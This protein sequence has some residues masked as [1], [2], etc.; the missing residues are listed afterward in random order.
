[1]G[2]SGECV[3]AAQGG[4]L[5]YMYMYVY[6]YV[7]MYVYMYMYMYMYVYVYVYMYVYMHMYMYVY[8]YAY[9]Y[10]YM[11]VCVYVRVYVYVYMYVHVC[12]YVYVSRNGPR[13]HARSSRGH[14][15]ERN[16]LEKPGMAT[17][18]PRNPKNQPKSR[19]F[20][21]RPS[22]NILQFSIDFG[23]SH[24]KMKKTFVGYFFGFLGVLV[25]IPGIS[26]RLR[27]GSQRRESGVPFRPVS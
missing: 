17:G 20:V 12:V 19:F 13:R 11:Y 22:S 27:S 1:M 18:T 9:V 10:V 21:F 23:T 2:K 16:R 4:T 15:G 5:M 25:A 8:V 14:P 6:V 24:L 26:E 3:A 7:Y